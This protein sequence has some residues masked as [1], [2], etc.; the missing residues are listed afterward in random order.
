MTILNTH[1][2]KF[3]PEVVGV[4]ILKCFN[5]FKVIN[6]ILGNLSYFK[7]TKFILVFYKRTTL[8]IIK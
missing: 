7:E 8:L 6:M 2:I 5:R 4:E 3:N 1:T